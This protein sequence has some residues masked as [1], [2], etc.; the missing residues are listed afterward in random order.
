MIC[1]LINILYT[2]KNKKNT[3]VFSL[4]I[5][6]KNK[7]TKHEKH[8]IDHITGSW[9]NNCKLKGSFKNGIDNTYTRTSP[10]Y[11]YMYKDGLVPGCITWKIKK[12]YLFTFS[13]FYT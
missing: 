3:S 7:N 11:L 2:N 9:V 12:E 6:W 5:K 10:P 13:L 4:S 8:N 1:L